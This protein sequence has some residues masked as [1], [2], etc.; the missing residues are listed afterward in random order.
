MMFTIA[1][2][3]TVEFDPSSRDFDTLGAKLAAMDVFKKI[4]RD[5]GSKSYFAAF[6]DMEME[7][8][9]AREIVDA[10]LEG[11]NTAVTQLFIEQ[12]WI[13]EADDFYWDEGVKDD[14]ESAIRDAIQTLADDIVEASGDES[15]DQDEVIEALVETIEDTLRSE[16]WDAMHEKDTSKVENCISE[17]KK[18]E[19]IFAPDLNSL[20][21]DD[22]MIDFDGY[23]LAL[24]TIVPNLSFVRML[25]FFNI[26]AGEY[27][28]AARGYIEDVRAGEL[29]AYE[30]AL[31]GNEAKEKARREARAVEREAMGL[32]AETNEKP[33]VEPYVPSPNLDS[34]ERYGQYWR[35]IEGLVNGDTTEAS[36]LDLPYSYSRDQWNAMVRKLDMGKDVSRPPALNMERLREVVENCGGNADI[37]CFVMKA[38]VKDILAGK[39]D[40][41][42]LAEG[43]LAGLHDFMNGAGHII[44]PDGPVL[45]DPAA[46]AWS[47]KIW[48]YSVDKVY[49]MTSS[50]YEAKVAPTEVSSLWPMVRQ[51]VYRHESKDGR[52]AEIFAQRD[53]DGE[54][55][56]WV[57]TFDADL[58]PSGPYETP[59][60]W[61]SMTEARDAAMQALSEEWEVER[62]YRP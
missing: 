21:A 1:E 40:G 9:T 62:S 8:S 41:P 60:V 37:P 57:T 22:I 33:L 55:E 34:H 2:G 45:L 32:D 28:Q 48:G 26:S 16:V 10:Y 25:Q 13:T 14:F 29:A 61:P 39:Y 53:S 24:D 59:E 30:A 50:A 19:F 6:G 31:P 56:F 35:A 51:D 47:T 42:V 43:G 44:R 52:A 17:H 20:S 36:R 38:R 5:V 46:G 15:L 11:G 4:A 12:K 27:I 3:Q 58:D 54:L 49:Y 7:D 18:I 23:Y